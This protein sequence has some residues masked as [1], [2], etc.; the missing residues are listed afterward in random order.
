M[1]G[2]VHMIARAALIA[3]VLIGSS[4]T[5]AVEPQATAAYEAAIDEASAAMMRDPGVALEAAQRA[6]ATI[7]TQAQ[8]AESAEMLARSEWLQ[9]EALTRLGR[10]VDA[11]PV[12]D[13]AINR[14]GAN[15]APTKLYADLRVARGRIAV[16]VGDFE[17]AFVSFTDAYEVFQRL[18]E[19]RSQA[20]VLQSIGS[21]YTAAHQYER[22]L[23]YFGD[24][25]DRY[26]DPSLDLA[27][28]NNR[29]NALR[30]LGRY[31]ES[32]ATYERARAAAAE[33]GSPMLEARIL[34]NI[35]A[36]HVNFEDYDAAEEALSDAQARLGALGAGE[37]TRFLDG[38]RAQIALGRGDLDR[39]RASLERTFDGV[40]LDASPQ[41]FTEFHEA[42]VRAYAG[43][44][45]FRSALDHLRAFK[46]LD[47]ESRNVA[48]SANSALLGAQFEFAEQ[49]L[50]IQQLRAER[51]EQDLALAAEQSRAKL[52]ALLAFT[53]IILAVLVAGFMRYRAEAARKRALATALYR[54]GETGLLSRKALEHRLEQGARKGL[55]HYVLAFEVDRH[56]HLRAA[57]GFAAF[58]E[59][60]AALAGRLS[61]AMPN[62]P[63]GVIAP[64]VLGVLVD[65]DTVD[66]Q[67]DDGLSTIAAPLRD[68]LHKPVRVGDL[69]IDVTVSGGAA[70][71]SL[72]DEAPDATGVIKQALVAIEQGRKKKLGFAEFDPALF[73]DPS[74]NL[75]IMSRMS[76]AMSNGELVLHYQPKLDLRTGE[77]KSAEA[78]MRWTDPERGYIPPD[79]YI[80]F[81]EETGQIRDLTEWSL[82]RA[83]I[84]QVALSKAGEEVMIAINIS[85]ALLTD[86]AFATRASQ[87]A[88]QS[89]AGLIFEVT[90]TAIMGDVDRSIRTLEMWSRSG[91]KISIDDYGTGQS[92]LAYLKRL[93]ADELKLDRAFIKEVET[94]QRDRMLVKS[95]VD[96][97][98]NLGLKLTAE[99]VEND[100]TLSVLKLM[101]CDSAQ[102]F[103]LC[104]PCSLI[105]LVGF[106]QRNRDA[107]SA[108]RPS[109]FA[110]PIGEDRAG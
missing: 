90:E 106:L 94:S 74:Q 28:L 88:M 68:R 27:A 52:M 82:E 31:E 89:R 16:A 73:G 70:L 13:S 14:L 5:H 92:S 26:S 98:H 7:A 97:A 51:L 83:L 25:M 79:S 1:T 37:W 76:A 110:K 108:P 32:L 11:A 15:P 4:A 39:A 78:L 10:P 67:A 84:D 50:Q 53:A 101:G 49:D 33:L 105:E 58:A 34:N 43:L 56:D 18:D 54:D 57:L 17:T 48:A 77:Y 44:G 36:L 71:C 30:E 9:A 100:E 93:P 85:S 95:T 65:F 59:L 69:D 80:L 72:S 22:A 99:G 3:A 2:N 62:S 12:A 46:R 29:A 6:A 103:G 66:D 87:L 35:A 47:D 45:D 64:G 38:V 20:I 42:A 107:A 41:N 86:A 75:A 8:S 24:A 102:G 23:T 21:I 104:R 61:E 63:V 60:K 96:L 109:A 81:A 55:E 40:P 91:V 19:T